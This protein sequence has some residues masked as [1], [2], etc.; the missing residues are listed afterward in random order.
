ML[1]S[2]PNLRTAMIGSRSSRINKLLQTELYHRQIRRN[3]C[4]APPPAL[5]NPLQWY[6]TKL[7]THPITTKVISSGLISGSGDLL[8]QSIIA[9]KEKQQ[10]QQPSHEYDWIRTLRFTI[11]GSFLVHRQ[12]TSGTA[13]L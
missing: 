12:S 13:C 11:L 9:R 4:G 8:C 5:R 3:L 10:Q 6:V 2:S 7:D 1:P